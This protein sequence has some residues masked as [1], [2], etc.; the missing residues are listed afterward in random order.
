MSGPGLRA[1]ASPSQPSGMDIHACP[2]GG[3][4]GGADLA[5]LSPRFP[6]HLSFPTC[7]PMLLSALLYL[8]TDQHLFKPSPICRPVRPFLTPVSAA[9]LSHPF[10][11]AAL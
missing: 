3:F 9:T 4:S 8:T 6:N 10:L 7:F 5:G 11:R 1:L 2:R